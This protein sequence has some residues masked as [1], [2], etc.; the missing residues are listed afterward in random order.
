ME[1]FYQVL[2]KNDGS[3]V[4]NIF[5][6]CH[7]DLIAKYITPD[8]VKN[9]TYFKATYR[10][11]VDHRL[12]DI[13]NYELVINEVYLP[14]WFVGG[15]AEDVI[16]KLQQI[17]KSMII[18][19]HR[20]LLLHEGAIL[21]GKAV[22][23]EMKHSVVF[24]MY[25]DSIIDVLDNASEVH[26]MTDDCYIVDMRD[27]TRVD[28]MMGYSRVKQMHDYSKIMKMYGQSKVGEMFDNSRI[29]MLKGDANIIEMHGMSQADR[30]KHMSKVD[31]MHG[32]SVIEEMWDWTVVEKMFD[33]SRINYMDEDS[34]V[35]EMHDESMIEQMHGN[36][37]VEKLFENSLVRKLSDAAQ[38]LKKEL[39]E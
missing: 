22:V 6:T 8:D 1:N 31:E 21:C 25:D 4:H 36:A 33:Q 12:D 28:E 32:H 15:L 37:V 7:K 2:I 39:G 34:K 13:F 18:T 27:S 5:A 23:S 9:K 38:I 14:E 24:A 16:I 3:V 20:Q 29:A 26:Y 19:N 11:K 17:I 35:C 10:P 30:L